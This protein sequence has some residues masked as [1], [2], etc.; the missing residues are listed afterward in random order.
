MLNQKENIY[1]V[2]K[3]TLPSDISKKDNDMVYIGITCQKPEYRWRNGEGYKQN[4]HFYNAIQKYS[5]DNYTHDILFDNLTKEEA[6]QK[7]IELIAYYNSTNSKFGYNIQAGGNLCGEVFEKPVICVETK[8]IYKSATEAKRILGISNA[9]ISACC[10]GEN[11]IAGGFHW[12]FAEEY[13]DDKVDELLKNTQSKKCKQVLCVDTGKIYNSITEASLDV[14]ISTSSIGGCCSGE[15]I[16]AG[17]FRW[18][19]LDDVTDE[20]VNEILNTEINIKGKTK[21]ICVETKQV[22]DNSVRASEYVQTSP[23][24]IRACCKGINKTAAGFHWMYLSDYTKHNA[25]NLLELP[26][27]KLNKKVICLNNGKIYETISEAALECGTY[28]TAISACCKGK[29]KSAGKSDCG[30][31]LYWKYYEDAYDIDYKNTLKS[32]NAESDD[33]DNFSNVVNIA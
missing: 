12:M 22:F 5:W 33:I 13:S 31:K 19:Y 7:E 11:K 23:S 14:G 2:Y 25:K 17:G 1:K 20:K 28:V 26:K 16:H 27:N 29:T 3:H 9:T 15:Y 4:A 32:L 6:E 21:V 24:G 10:R 8:T 30:E 18:M